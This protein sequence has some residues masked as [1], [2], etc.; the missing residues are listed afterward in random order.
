MSSWYLNCLLGAYKNSSQYLM[1]LHVK[2]S[3]ADAW[4]TWLTETRFAGNSDYEHKI[5]QEVQAYIL[6]VLQA[7]QIQ[8]G[9]TIADIGTGEGVLAF[10]AL[11]TTPS[12]HAILTDS[13]SALLEAAK[14]QAKTLGVSSQCRFV[15]SDS[16]YLHEIDDASVDVVL[17]RS[18]LAYV[19]DKKS[20][21]SEFM[22]ILKPGGRISLAEPIMR[23]DAMAV[24]DLKSALTSNTSGNIDPFLPLLHRWR[25][26]WYPDNESAIERAHFCNFSERDLIEYAR[27]AGF[28]DIHME[29]HVDITP[30]NHHSWDIFLDMTP[31]PWASPLRSLLHQTFTADER[32]LFERVFRPI[33]ENSTAVQVHRM[34]YLSA[35]KNV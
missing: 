32:A 12:L 29:F 17:T 31:H 14:K 7:A 22:R 2:S 16:E 30:A 23:D 28:V 3:L 21:L 34:A 8:P 20:T 27:N 25:A 10:E 13:S 18:S 19:A 5:R 6:K 4:S 24:K 9:M 26:A 35:N 11:R 33:V 1:S 15:E